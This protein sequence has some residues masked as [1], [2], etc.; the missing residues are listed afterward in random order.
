MKIDKNIFRSLALINQIGISMLVP[1]F[2]SI[3]IGNKLDQ[4]FSTSYLTIVFLFL[5]ILAAFRNVYHLTKSFY[6][7]D[8]SKE[9]KTPSANHHL[10]GSSK[11]DEK[12]EEAFQKWINDHDSDCENKDS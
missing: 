11:K 12:I 3:Y 4:W 9:A 2:L 6:K 5:G 1:I 8:K 7:N 10:A